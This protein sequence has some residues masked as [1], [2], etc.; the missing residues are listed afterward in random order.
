MESLYNFVSNITNWFTGGKTGNFYAYSYNYSLADPLLAQTM[1]AN[2]NTWTTGTSLPNTLQ[3]LLQYDGIFVGELSADNN[4]ITDYVKAGGNVYVLAGYGGEPPEIQAEK[5]NRFLG[6]FG[7]AFSIY[8]DTAY[9][10][11]AITTVDSVHPLFKNVNSI[12]Y[13]YGNGVRDLKPTDSSQK[14]IFT[15]PETGNALRTAFVLPR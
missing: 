15:E 11:D 6:N 9:R 8:L 5:W 7:L 4:L 13:A 10:G 2:G 1:R 12:Y 14:I 3:G